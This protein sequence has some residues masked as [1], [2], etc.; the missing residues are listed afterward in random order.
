MYIY[1]YTHTYTCI[2]LRAFLPAAMPAIA[3]DINSDSASFGDISS[4]V[5]SLLRLRNRAENQRPV[6]SMG[7]WAPWQR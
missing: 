4:D 2:N 7:A 6:G 1:I 3:V 5:F